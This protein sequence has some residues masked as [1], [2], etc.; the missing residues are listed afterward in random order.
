MSRCD[1]TAL[2]LLAAAAALLGA[3]GQAEA[4]VLATFAGGS[5]VFAASLATVL[6]RC[7]DG[8]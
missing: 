3:A 2:V 7:G 1:L 5:A 8:A 6:W 4:R